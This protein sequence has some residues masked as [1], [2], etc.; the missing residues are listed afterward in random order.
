MC[1]EATRF[2]VRR[3]ADQIIRHKN[4]RWPRNLKTARIYVN[5]QKSYYQLC[6][7]N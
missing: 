4:V 7:H 5:P 2:G 6:T 3:T 1:K